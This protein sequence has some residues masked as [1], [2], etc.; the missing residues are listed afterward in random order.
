MNY[1]RQITLI[2]FSPT[3]NNMEILSNLYKEVLFDDDWW[4]FLWEGKETFLRVSDPISTSVYNPATPIL[5]KVKIFLDK[6]KVEYSVRNSWWKDNI[7]ITAHYQN[8]FTYILHGFSVMAMNLY[9]NRNALS[10]TEKARDILGIMERIIHLFSNNMSMQ[11]I[12]AEDLTKALTSYCGLGLSE[13]MLM[14][15]TLF[16]G[17]FV[18]GW[19]YLK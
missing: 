9:E 19:R 5:G 6:N 16:M 18:S 17:T 12:S 11:S 4:H 2:D 10:K 1:L 14:L 3:E 13:P 8:E 15:T 7:K